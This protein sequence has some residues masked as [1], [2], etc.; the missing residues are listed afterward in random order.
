MAKAQSVNKLILDVS[1]I[2][3]SINVRE[4][5]KM[6]FLNLLLEVQLKK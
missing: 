1:Q 2:S 4:T 5:V 3:V 6:I